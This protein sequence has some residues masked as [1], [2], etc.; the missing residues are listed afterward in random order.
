MSIP[1]L[2][3]KSSDT[4]RNFNLKGLFRSRST[5]SSDDRQTISQYLKDAEEDARRCEVEAKKLLAAMK[6][7]ENRKKGLEK[8]MEMYR[9]LLSPVHKLP[10]EILSNI[11]GLCCEDNEL[12]YDLDSPEVMNLSMVCGRWRDLVLSTPTLWSTL[13]LEASCFRTR[14]PT[15]ELDTSLAEMVKLFLERSK[16][17]PLKL[18]FQSY[19]NQ[20]VEPSFSAFDLLVSE[21]ERWSDITFGSGGF[22]ERLPT[23][24]HLPML[25]HLCLPYAP[26]AHTDN[27][28]NSPALVS[29][30]LTPHLHGDVVLPWDRIKIL[31]LSESNAADSLSVLSR[32]SGLEKLEFVSTEIDGT[33]EVIGPITFPR[34]QSLSFYS[35]RPEILPIFQFARFPHLSTLIFSGHVIDSDGWEDPRVLPSVQGLLQSQCTITSLTL[36]RQQMDDHQALALL[37]LL[38]A[39]QSLEVREYLGNAIVTPHF[40]KWLTVEDG[41]LSES[42]SILPR[43]STL[44]LDVYDKGLDAEAFSNAVVSR[45]KPAPDHRVEC[46]QSVD[47]TV[48]ASGD[49]ANWRQL[50][51]LEDFRAAGLRFTHTL[52]QL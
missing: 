46:L 6:T 34:L 49:E 10:S 20:P 27:F 13:R 43:L 45:W 40:L 16:N 17:T 31:T 7:L 14:R 36:V 50:V 4:L 41:S 15:R 33:E 24:R 18:A 22:L 42:S 39:L 48:R 28:S 8:S 23:R 29:V 52:I 35:F 19:I 30:E 12:S 21:M 37:K 25:K 9:S 11:F 3:F 44:T 47:I 1:I 26:M 5:I 32:C 38:P 51:W 2:S